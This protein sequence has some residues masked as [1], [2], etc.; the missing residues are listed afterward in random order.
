M[1][2]HMARMGDILDAAMRGSSVVFSFAV[3]T[4]IWGWRGTIFS[5]KISF[6][7][8][9]PTRKITN[10]G[11]NLRQNRRA[12][13]KDH[14]KEQVHILG[15]LKSDWHLG[16]TKYYEVSR[17]SAKAPHPSW[18]AP[19]HIGRIGVS[20]RRHTFKQKSIAR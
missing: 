1:V 19:G 18:Q 4:Q 9:S 7:T 14:I 3:H 17:S 10:I 8:G 5:F 20:R 15:K 2:C 6:L 11:L 16:P 12:A 13:S